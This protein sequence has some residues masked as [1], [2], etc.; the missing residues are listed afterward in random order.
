MLSD[1]GTY[2]ARLHVDFDVFVALGHE[3]VVEAL[4][5]GDTR[6]EKVRRLLVDA[7]HGRQAA[8]LLQG[9]RRVPQ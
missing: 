2:L 6:L 9:E 5:R 1:R 4:E 7:E 3:V 8:L